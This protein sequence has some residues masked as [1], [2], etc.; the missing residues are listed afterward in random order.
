MATFTE[1]HTEAQDTAPWERRGPLV[2][3]LSLVPFPRWCCE[4]FPRSSL[5]TKGPVPLEQTQ[6]FTEKGFSL[7]MVTPWFGPGGGPAGTARDPEG[8][9]EPSPAT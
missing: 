4:A 2:W 7:F 6:L 1:N 5:V 8:Y 9:T 3:V